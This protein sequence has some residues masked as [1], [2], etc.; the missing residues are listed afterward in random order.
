MTNPLQ[1]THKRILY[2]SRHIRPAKP[3]CESLTFRGFIFA[4]LSAAFPHVPRSRAINKLFVVDRRSLISLLPRRKIVAR[5]S[6]YDGR[7]IL[8]R[9]FT[10]GMQKCVRARSI[11]IFMVETVPP[12]LL[13]P[14]IGLGLGRVG[15][16]IGSLTQVC[17]SYFNNLQLA[18]AVL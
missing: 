2:Y 13:S 10:V 6:R 3:T 17:M 9:R 16:P 15:E 1:A 11:Y 14:S 8:I 7:P 18:C 4:H 5:G 12:G